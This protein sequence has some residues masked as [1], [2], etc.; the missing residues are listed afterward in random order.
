MKGE[1]ENKKSIAYENANK[2]K[3]QTM[4]LQGKLYTYT[5]TYIKRMRKKKTNPKKQQHFE[6]TISD[7]KTGKKSRAAS[8]DAKE[9]ARSKYK[10]HSHT[11]THFLL[12][13]IN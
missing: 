7:E 1:R 10:L 3:K 8:D 4:K 11:H 6:E 2:I 5:H 13:Y 9:G 12:S